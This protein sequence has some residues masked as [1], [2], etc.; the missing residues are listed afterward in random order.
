MCKKDTR[1]TFDKSQN[2]T[3]N[4]NYNTTVKSMN[5]HSNMQIY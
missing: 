4:K 2:D 3:Q 1:N 5:K